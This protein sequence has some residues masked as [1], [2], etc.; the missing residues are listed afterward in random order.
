MLKL[1]ISSSETI[2]P[3]KA[4]FVRYCEEKSHVS[5]EDHQITIQKDKIELQ[6]FSR[7][8]MLQFISENTVSEKINVFNLP[9]LVQ[10]ISGDQFY[11]IL[12]FHK[13]KGKIYILNQ[14]EDKIT[15]I[16]RREYSRYFENIINQ[17][18]YK[19]SKSDPIKFVLSK[20][21]KELEG[22]SLQDKLLL[23]NQRLSAEDKKFYRSYFIII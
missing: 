9:F 23:I 12:I 5:G 14:H 17:Q 13:R 4:I 7:E 11:V 21:R 6:T 10:N 3:K 15:K 2:Y 20:N 8:N 19:F 18:N 1:I 22:K 16:I